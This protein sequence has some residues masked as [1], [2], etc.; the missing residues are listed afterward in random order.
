M[1]PDTLLSCVEPR[2]SSASLLRR[3][4]YFR[5]RQESKRP[6]SPFG[7]HAP[8]IIIQSNSSNQDQD[9][10]PGNSREHSQAKSHLCTRPIASEIQGRPVQDRHRRA[11]CRALSCGRR[12]PAES[13]SRARVGSLG[14]SRNPQAR[15]V[16]SGAPP[17]PSANASSHGC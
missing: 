8:S 11:S 5:R 2:S 7:D 15:R 14:I 16:A 9:L 10:R 17:G 12:F 3:G 4:V 1:P 13:E 6:W